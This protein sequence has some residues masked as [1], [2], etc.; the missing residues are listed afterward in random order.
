MYALIL[1]LQNQTNLRSTIQSSDVVSVRRENGDLER[2]S[3][4]DL[5]PGDVVIIP[6]TGCELT[7]DAVLVS[8]T[9]IGNAINV[10]HKFQLPLF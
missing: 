1:M 5:V 10:W 3:S 9:A 8:G 4:D 7:Y 2:V 6:P